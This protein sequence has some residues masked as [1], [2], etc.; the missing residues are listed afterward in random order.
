MFPRSLRVQACLLAAA[1]LVLLF[2]VFASIY[3]LFAFEA[4][5]PFEAHACVEC[6]AAVCHI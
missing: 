4:S 2:L 3:F 5:Y 6:V 1:N